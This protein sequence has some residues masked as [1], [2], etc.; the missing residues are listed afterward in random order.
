[1]IFGNDVA[2]EDP[3]VEQE[4]EEETDPLA[5]EE[6]EP[7]GKVEEADHSVKCITCFA[8]SVEFYP[9][10]NKNCFGCGSPDHPIQDCLKDISRST[11]KAYLNRK[12]GM[13]KKGG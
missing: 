13:A 11:Q 5:D 12:Q 9:K 10:K 4:G 6:V 1:M 7:L 3:G 8:K 2:E